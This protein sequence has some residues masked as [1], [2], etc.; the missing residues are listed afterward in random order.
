MENFHDFGKKFFT[1]QSINSK[2]IGILSEQILIASE[3]NKQ[4]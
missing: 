3:K 1:K 2:I 4:Y